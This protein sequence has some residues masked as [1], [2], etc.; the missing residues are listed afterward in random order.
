MLFIFGDRDPLNPIGEANV[1][2][3]QSL[4]RTLKVPRPVQ[5]AQDWARAMGC[6]TE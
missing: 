2:H 5:T 6:S 4:T 3:R 1:F